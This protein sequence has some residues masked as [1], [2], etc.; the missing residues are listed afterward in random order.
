M[1]DHGPLGRDVTYADRYDPSLLH[2]IPRAEGRAVLGLTTGLPFQ[3]CDIWN[4][5]EL[6]WLE[7]SGRPRVAVMEMRV[8]AESPC[9]VESKSLK[10]YLNSFNNSVFPNHDEVCDTIL[11][12][13]SACVGAPL[14]VVLAGVESAHADGFG[15]VRAEG[16]CIDDE[17]C[18]PAS[19][20]VEP[21]RLRLATSGD[22]NAGD[23]SSGDPSSE[24]VMETFVSHLLRSK[25]PVTSQPDWASVIIRYEGPRIDRSSLLGYIVSYR[26][27]NE[28]H[29]Q[30]VERM[31]VDIKRQCASL[32]LSVAARY[33]RRGGLDINPFRSDFEP[34]PVNARLVRQ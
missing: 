8:P 11:R 29:E 5:W 28:F 22:S 18:E 19:G 13:V 7:P 17:P 31:F 23:R 25:C 4:A 27:H 26:N 6:S 33:M 30:C 14:T 21:E 12:D 34:A 9:I 32:R 10:L 20:D 15:V 3:G 2:A 1:I 24:I 16:I